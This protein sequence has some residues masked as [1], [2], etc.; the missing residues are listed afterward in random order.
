MNDVYFMQQA[1]TK[2]KEGITAGQSP[3]GACIVKD[4]T[5]LCCAHNIVWQS[6][7]ITAHAEINAIRIACNKLNFIDLSGCTMYTTCEPCPMCFSAAHWARIDRIVFGSRVAD[8]Q[9]YGFNEL[10][11]SNQQMQ[12]LGKST[13]KITGD[14]LREENLELFTLWSAQENKRVY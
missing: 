8:A 5:I 12:Q 14:F 6:T 7:D 4:K 3:F 11:I 2:A 1:I 10:T 9:K 13:I